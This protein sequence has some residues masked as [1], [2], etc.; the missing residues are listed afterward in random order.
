MPVGTCVRA[1]AS[2]PQNVLDRRD[3]L[4]TQLVVGVAFKVLLNAL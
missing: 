4:T 3:A 1:D 2:A